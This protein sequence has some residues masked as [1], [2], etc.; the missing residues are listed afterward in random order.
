[1]LNLTDR[2]KQE[3]VAATLS[4]DTFHDCRIGP[5]LAQLPRSADRRHC[6]QGKPDLAV[7]ARLVAEMTAPNR[8]KVEGI[9][10]H[11]SSPVEAKRAL[12]GTAAATH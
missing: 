8:H 3:T 1:M 6:L 10:I 11:L 5:Q 7:I 4:S 12:H 9:R 2:V